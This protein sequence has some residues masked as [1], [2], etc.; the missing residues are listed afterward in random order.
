MPCRG[1]L[2]RKWESTVDRA[3]IANTMM[4]LNDMSAC[5]LNSMEEQMSKGT[6]KSLGGPFITQAIFCEKILHEKDGV[7]TPVRIVDTLTAEIIPISEEGIGQ[8]KQ[9]K[10]IRRQISALITIKSGD[11]IG[12]RTVKIHCKSLSVDMSIP[13]VFE[14]GHHGINLSLNLGLE[15]TEGVHWF[16]LVLSGKLLTKFPLRAVIQ[17][18]ETDTTSAESQTSALT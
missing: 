13:V 18:G 2:Q 12:K 4:M 1:S 14:G 6:K 3:L 11:I 7:L 10:K 5:M 17:L 9:V 8:A 15:L 16:S